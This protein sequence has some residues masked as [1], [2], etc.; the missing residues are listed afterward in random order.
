MTGRN[1]IFSLYLMNEYDNRMNFGAKVI[2]FLQN[3]VKRSTF[4]MILKKILL[5][6][7]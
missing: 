5:C 3:S 1:A 7:E 6:C 4:A 2:I